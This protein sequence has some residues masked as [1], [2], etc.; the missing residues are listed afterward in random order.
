[1]CFQK[2]K[3]K[4]AKQDNTETNQ[5]IENFPRVYVYFCCYW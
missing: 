2:S 5:D 3:F 4:L 1:M